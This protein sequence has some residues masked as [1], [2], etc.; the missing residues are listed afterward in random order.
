MKSNTQ[1]NMEIKSSDI[2]EFVKFNTGSKRW[3]FK[4]QEVVK[5]DKMTKSQYE[6][7]IAVIIQYFTGLRMNEVAKLSREQLIKLSKKQ[8]IRV[9]LSKTKYKKERRID[10]RPKNNRSSKTL[11][12]KL[13]QLIKEWLQFEKSHL[14]TAKNMKHRTGVKIK[15]KN[16][17]EYD[18]SY[19][20]YIH[21]FIYKVNKLLKAFVEYKSDKDEDILPPHIEKLT[22]HGLRNNFIVATYRNKNNDLVATKRAIHHSDLSTTARYIDKYLADI[23]VAEM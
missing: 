5:D 3:N 7:N 8:A 10:I 15:K 23:D 2:L 9:S 14:V 16:G 4:L 11:H 21:N 22:T 20:T 6:T 13:I 1:S 12:R 18:T 17:K 19:L